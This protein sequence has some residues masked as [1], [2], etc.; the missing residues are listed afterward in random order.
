MENIKRILPYLKAHRKWLLLAAL[1]M[2][3][4]A[5]FNIAYIAFVKPLIDHLGNLRD[6]AQLLWIVCLIPVLFFFKMLIQYTQSYL[7][8]YVGQKTIQQIRED[9]FRHLHDLSIEFY[10]RNRT[11]EIM[12][13]VTNDLNSVQSAVQFL[14]LYFV[15]DVLSIVFIMG[16]LFYINWRFTLIALLIGPFA[17]VV[18]GVLGRKMR[19]A[20]KQAQEIVGHIYHRFQESLEGMEVVKAFNYEESSIARFK[21]QN[22]NFFSQMMR[23][24]RATALSGPLMEF[25]GSIVISLLLYYG[26]REIISGRMTPGDF[27]AFLVAFFLAYNP[28]KNIAQANSSLQIGLVS[29]GRIL[30]LLNE[31]PDVVELPDA[32]PVAKLSGYIKFD[33][34]T[35]RYPTGERDALKNVSL[36]IRPGEKVAFVGPSGSGKTTIINLLLRL[37]D[38]VSGKISYD[39][40][41]LKT[42]KIHDLRSHIGLVGQH[43]ILFDE[44]VY[45]NLAMGLQGASREEVMAAATA[46][47]ADS[48]I[49]KLPKKY[50]TM[51]GER[52][53]KLSGGQRQRLAIARA[54]LKKPSVLLLDEATSNLDTTSE[55]YV[56]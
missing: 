24:L 21:Q 45:E 23:Y 11:G 8:S 38:P 3:G 13:K 39:G 56:Q 25:L 42:L 16:Y 54:V 32:L 41:D 44:S 18:L 27:A 29:W 6:N 2:V 37:F 10:W 35:Y 43:T 50:D 4:V 28:L 26:G 7:M 17:G 31:K 49:E 36:E 19:R 34:V 12:A 47:D 14:P 5:A 52:G 51:L 1:A 9:L 46:A 40:A 48:F 55:K 33:N 53:V 15:R 30:T 22:D 20:S